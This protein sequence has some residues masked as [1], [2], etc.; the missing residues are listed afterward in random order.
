MLQQHLTNKISGVSKFLVDQKAK[1]P[2]QVV[3]TITV[4]SSWVRNCMRSINKSVLYGKKLYA[5]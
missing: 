5:Y 2:A 4:G 1:V 3:T